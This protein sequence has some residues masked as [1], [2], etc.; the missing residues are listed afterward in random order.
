MHKPVN[1]TK[2]YQHLPVALELGE[3]TQI[4]FLMSWGMWWEQIVRIYDHFRT[5]RSATT[6][7]LVGQLCVVDSE[8]WEKQEQRPKQ[9]QQKTMILF[10]SKSFFHSLD[11][12]SQVSQLQ[13]QLG[14]KWV[15]ILVRD[16]LHS[17]TFLGI[18]NTPHAGSVARENKHFVFRSPTVDNYCVTTC[19]HEFTRIVLCASS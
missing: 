17:T 7:D 16:Q 11:L 4:Q 3:R 5:P 9:E 6:L 12:V 18:K 2:N 19:A 1:S 8:C 13:S 15:T 14:P 10:C